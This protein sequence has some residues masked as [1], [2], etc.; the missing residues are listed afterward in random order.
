MMHNGYLRNYLMVII[1]FITVLTGYRFFTTIPFHLEIRNI[2]QFETHELLIFIIMVP[3]V[4]FTIR[5]NSKLIAVASMGIIGFAMCLMFVLSGAPASA[6]T[7]FT[8]DTLTVVLCVLILY[9][10]PPF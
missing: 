5:A 10:L 3:A 4:F 1:V 8:I 6:M 2:T 9:K 7:Q